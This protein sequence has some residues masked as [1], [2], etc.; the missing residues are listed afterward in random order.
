MSAAPAPPP[1]LHP[2]GATNYG[3]ENEGGRRA[4]IVDAN[5]NNGHHGASGRPQRVLPNI[6]DLVYE[7]ESRVDI[8][9]PVSGAWIRLVQL[10]INRS[11][12]C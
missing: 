8:H 12:P 1:H 5:G 6:R 2:I 7:A 10:T 9:E 11:K 3:S 4:S